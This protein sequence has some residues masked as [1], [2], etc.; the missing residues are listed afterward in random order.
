MKLS[1]EEATVAIQTL[2]KIAEHEVAVSEWQGAEYFEQCV[3]LAEE[4]LTKIG[5]KHNPKI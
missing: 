5:V 3:K 1:K 2:K 4:A